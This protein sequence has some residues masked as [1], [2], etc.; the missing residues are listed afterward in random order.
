MEIILPNAEVIEIQSRMDAVVSE[1]TGSRMF[2]VAVTEHGCQYYHLTRN[3]QAR[4]A[5]FLNWVLR[6]VRMEHDALMV[7][8]V[9]LEPWFI[10]NGSVAIINHALFD[11]ILPERKKH[12]QTVIDWLHFHSCYPTQM[13]KAGELKEAIVLD[14]QTLTRRMTDTH[15]LWLWWRKGKVYYDVLD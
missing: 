14:G 8:V 2:I 12:I 4:I 1:S 6:A 10:E 13:K 11:R 5:P 9:N 3:V 15:H 7:C